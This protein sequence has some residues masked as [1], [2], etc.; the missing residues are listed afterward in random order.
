MQTPTFPATVTDTGRLCFDV[1]SRRGLD[2]WLCSLAGTHALVSVRKDRASLSERQRRWYFGEILKRITEHTGQD[3][4]DL[5]LY[6]KD[7]FLGS[8]D[9]RLLVLV[10][11]HGDVVDERDLLDGPSITTLSTTAMA[12]YCD[13]I[14][15]FA[16]DRLQV[17]IPNPDPHWRALA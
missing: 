1:A 9:H 8:P 3:V 14:R 17:D 10:D 16:A 2:R 4:D 15:M 12:D 7:R 5:H 6:F 13:Q 11:G